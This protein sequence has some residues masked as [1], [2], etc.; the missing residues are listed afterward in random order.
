MVED[1]KKVEYLFS[2]NR[3][4][5]KPHKFEKLQTNI[6]KIG[7]LV[8]AGSPEGGSTT[9][10]SLLNLKSPISR[11]EIGQRLRSSIG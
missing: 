11:P 10:Y 2:V 5:A 6:L 7:I 9:V 4:L 3:I 8:E 1:Y